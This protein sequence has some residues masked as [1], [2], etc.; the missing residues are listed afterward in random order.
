MVVEYTMDHQKCY[1]FGNPFLD[2]RSIVDSKQS[3]DIQDLFDWCPMRGTAS[4]TGT[5]SC[6]FGSPALEH[7]EF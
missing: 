2:C 7:G 4:D 5:F 3:A 1:P 6:P